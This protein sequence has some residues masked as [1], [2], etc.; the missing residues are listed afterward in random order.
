MNLITANRACSL[1]YSYIAQHNLGTWLLPVNVCPD[2]PLTFCLADVKFEF[3]D[4]NSNTLCIDQQGCLYKITCNPTQYAGI[5]YVRTY[6]TLEDTSGF[7]AECRMIKSNLN[8]IDDR[9]LCLPSV[10]PD[11][12][13]ADMVLYSTGHCKQIDLGGGGFAFTKSKLNLL[14]NLRYEAVDE[15]AIYKKAYAN[16]KPL[17]LIPQGWLQ[18][19]PNEDD[20]EH[21]FSVINDK[22]SQRL[23]QR[24]ALNEI[25]M[26]NLPA[27]IAFDIKFQ[28]WRFNITVP[29]AIKN[30]LLQELFSKHLFA[31]NH[32]HCANKLFDT[33]CFANGERLFDTTINLFNDNNYNIEMAMKTC[34]IINKVL[35]HTGGG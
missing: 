3:V 30:V 2:V 15:E 23:S 33:R 32:Y 6:G 29:T 31:S 27:E 26:E 11:T 7:F 20:E 34:D 13:G 4:I 22:L 28:E 8:I 35:A 24:N 18:V 14:D 1:L 9:C 21:Y 19:S 5:V 17:E 16:Q 10:T 12:Y 25:Y